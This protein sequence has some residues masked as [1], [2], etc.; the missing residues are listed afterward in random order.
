MGFSLE[1]GELETM[2]MMDSAGIFKCPDSMTA[3][4]LHAVA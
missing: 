3:L 4:L 2:K 1:F